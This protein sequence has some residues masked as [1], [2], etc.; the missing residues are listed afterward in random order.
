[1]SA[2]YGYLLAFY[3]LDRPYGK[4][5]AILEDLHSISQTSDQNHPI[6]LKNGS[7]VFTFDTVGFLQ[8]GDLLGGCELIAGGLS[9]IWNRGGSDSPTSL[10]LSGMQTYTGSRL[11][12]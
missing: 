9:A 11:R 6:R 1:M 4:K 2:Y 5:P 8:Q 7:E 3:P 10:R 12:Y